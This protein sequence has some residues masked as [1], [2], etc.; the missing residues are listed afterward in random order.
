[1]TA[2]RIRMARIIMNQDDGCIRC[3]VQVECAK[4]H[5]DCEE[6]LMKWA[7]ETETE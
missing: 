5:T 7:E 3:P 6:L 2:D 4:T 1:M